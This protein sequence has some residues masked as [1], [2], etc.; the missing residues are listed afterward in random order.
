MEPVQSQIGHHRP[1]QR[2]PDSCRSVKAVCFL[3]MAAPWPA[4]SQNADGWSFF[5]RTILQNAE[6]RHEKSGLQHMLSSVPVLSCNPVALKELELQFIGNAMTNKTQPKRLWI[7]EH[8]KWAGIGGLVGV[9]ALIF[10][11]F[12]EIKSHKEQT[13]DFKVREQSNRN[14]EYSFIIDNTGDRK[15]SLE[16]VRLVIT[17]RSGPGKWNPSEITRN[18]RDYVYGEKF[19]LLRAGEYKFTHPKDRVKTDFEI[20]SFNPG[21]SRKFYFRTPVVVEIERIAKSAAKKW[22]DETN[23]LKFIDKQAHLEARI[24]LVSQGKVAFHIS[25][26]NA[27]KCF[28][29]LSNSDCLM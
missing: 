9:A 21:E 14:G 28:L 16:S 27:A 25:A 24:E 2:N 23:E 13:F 19:L 15:I 22:Q 10:S 20:K 4:P 5:L 11:I 1:A 12:V 3:P 7:L 18:S 26:T 8:P 17:Q 29:K 6:S